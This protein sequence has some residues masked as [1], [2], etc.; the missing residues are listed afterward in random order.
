MKMSTPGMKISASKTFKVSP[1]SL[2]GSN[3]VPIRLNSA[4]SNN[5]SNGHNLLSTIIAIPF[6]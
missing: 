4:G 6:K 2:L 3:N 1:A 5:S